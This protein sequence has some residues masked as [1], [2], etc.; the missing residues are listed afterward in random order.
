MMKFYVQHD[1]SGKNLS[2]VQSSQKIEGP[3]VVEFDSIPTPDIA[4][5]KLDLD[6]GA[7]VTD[8]D[9]VKERHNNG[10]QAQLRDLDG[11]RS[12]AISDWIL[13]QDTGPLQNIEAQRQE[14][15]AQLQ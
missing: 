13:T 12:R 9:K 7:L 11:K 14:L 1:G 3:N 4:I 6:T 15:V 5:L 10:I 8:P 2:V